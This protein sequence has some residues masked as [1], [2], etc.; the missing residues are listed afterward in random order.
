MV[1]FQAADAGPTPA[2]RIEIQK[3]PRSRGFLNYLLFYCLHSNL[4]LDIR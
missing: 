4:S 1:A 2:S 3:P